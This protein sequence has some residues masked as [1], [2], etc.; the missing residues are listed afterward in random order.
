MCTMCTTRSHVRQWEALDKVWL[1][2]SAACSQAITV[3]EQECQLLAGKSLSFS[4]NQPLS[5]LPH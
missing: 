1:F 4:G 5:L 3:C 2:H